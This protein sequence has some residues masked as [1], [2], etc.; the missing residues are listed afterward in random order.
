[1]IVE[2]KRLFNPYVGEEYEKGING[3]KILFLD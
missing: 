3:K 1:M 2:K